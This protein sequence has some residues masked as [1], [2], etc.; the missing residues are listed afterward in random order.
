MR[1]GKALRL[2]GAA[3]GAAL[4]SYATY[5]AMPWIRYG[6]P[7]PARHP[8]DDLVDRCQRAT[9]KEHASEHNAAGSIAIDDQIRASAEDQGLHCQT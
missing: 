6:S 7:D 4:A 2:A 9:Q 1:S 5:S 8:A 3:A